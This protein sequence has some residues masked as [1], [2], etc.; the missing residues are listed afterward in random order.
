MQPGKQDRCPAVLLSMGLPRDG[1]DLATEQKQP[2]LTF[3]CPQNSF[4]IISRVSALTDEIE[5]KKGCCFHSA[6]YKIAV[7]ES[8]E[9]Q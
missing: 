9:K 5:K 6:V 8:A 2:L 7:F 4:R 1:H 3:F